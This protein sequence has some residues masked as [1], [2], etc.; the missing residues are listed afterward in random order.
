M[1]MLKNQESIQ[2]RVHEIM[3]TYSVLLYLHMKEWEMPKLGM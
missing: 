2:S 1:G 3:M